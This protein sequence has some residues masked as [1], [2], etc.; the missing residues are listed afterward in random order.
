MPQVPPAA[1]ELGELLTLSP[2][3][4]RELAGSA[5]ARGPPSASRANAPADNPAHAEMLPDRALRPGFRLRAR[6]P[7]ADDADT[8]PADSQESGAEQAEA[9]PSARTPAARAASRGIP[10]MSQPG[11]VTAP[12]STVS[13]R[14]SN[15]R[16][17]LMLSAASDIFRY[18]VRALRV[19]RF[20]TQKAVQATVA[21]MDSRNG[22]CATRRV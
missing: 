11:S 15:L 22:A 6:E 1:A 14:T 7:E 10:G 4:S 16:S 13:L 9:G 18:P 8:W 3:I 5:A 21:D 17:N 2:P 20:A 12:P 19:A